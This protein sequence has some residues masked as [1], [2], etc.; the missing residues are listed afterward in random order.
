MNDHPWFFWLVP[1][2]V[3]TLLAVVGVMI[4]ARPKRDEEPHESVAQHEKF[5][6]AMDSQLPKK[7]APRPPTDAD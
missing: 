5:R 6:R 4:Y 1:I 3:F 2:V 7:R